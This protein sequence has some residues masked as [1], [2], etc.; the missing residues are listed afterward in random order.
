M[1]SN[2]ESHYED[3]RYPA[4]DRNRDAREALG[5]LQSDRSALADRVATPGWYYPLLALATAAIVGSPIG[6]GTIW[7]SLLVT[8]ASL[9]IV[10]LALA[11]QKKTG[12]TITHT[13][14]PRSL[15]VAIVMGVVIVLL[16]GVSFALAATGNGVWIIASALAAFLVMWLGGRAYDRAFDRELRRGR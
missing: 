1:V 2:M 9:G 7:Q 6:T 3:S 8:F 5:A 11:Y 14:G 13:A 16:L 4:D 12:V 15:T 10:F